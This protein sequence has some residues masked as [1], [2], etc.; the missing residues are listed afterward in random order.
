MRFWAA[1]LSLWITAGAAAAAPAEVRGRA[2][3]FSGDT[4][5][6]AGQR[7]RLYG[8][9]APEPGQ[10]CRWPNKVIDCGQI[11]RAALLDLIAPI[12]IVCRRRAV[13]PDGTWLAS[14]DAEGF[15]V[16]RNMI[17]TGWAV[18]PEND[19]A[20]WA[21]VQARAKAR[22]RGLWKGTFVMPWQWKA[23]P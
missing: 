10:K 16:G 4:L 12:D 1:L 11:S 20:R 5:A 7:I 19:P 3:V 21:G 2:T 13:L 17:F 18:I 22:R 15:D 9:D 23:K 8:I 14:C 6:V